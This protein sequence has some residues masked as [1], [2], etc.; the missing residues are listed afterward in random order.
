MIKVYIEDQNKTFVL[1]TNDIVADFPYFGVDG[2]SGVVYECSKIIK[3]SH[4]EYI[5]VMNKII[6]LDYN[7]NTINRINELKGRE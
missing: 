3:I 4:K 2:H 6:R 7:E 5:V 1:E